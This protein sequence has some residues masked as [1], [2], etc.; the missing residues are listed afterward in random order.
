MERS[1]EEKVVNAAWQNQMGSSLKD[2][3]SDAEIEQAVQMLADILVATGV[4]LQEEE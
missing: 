4:Q 3:L 2:F 1:F